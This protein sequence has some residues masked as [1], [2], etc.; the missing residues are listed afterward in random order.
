MYDHKWCIY[1]RFW[2]T[3]LTCNLHIECEV[4]LCRE[5]VPSM[6]M[7]GEV[8]PCR[9]RLALWLIEQDRNFQLIVNQ[10]TACCTR[11]V[12]AIDWA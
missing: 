8:E 7:E 2:S 9:S 6:H 5:G 4:E 10:L 1:I 12:A 11:F 3:L